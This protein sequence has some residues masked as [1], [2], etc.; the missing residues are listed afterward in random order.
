[1][2][3]PSY[4][5]MVQT[6]PELMLKINLFLTGAT[7]ADMA[8]VLWAHRTPMTTDAGDESAVDV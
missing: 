8:E 6:W 4:M 5:E 1:M 3:L 7:E 2:K